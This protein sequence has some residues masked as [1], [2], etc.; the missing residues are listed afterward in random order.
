MKKVNITLAFDDEKLDA[1]EFSLKKESSSVQERMDETLLKLYEKTVAESLREY[2]ESRAVPVAKEK[3][4]RP[5]KS[6]TPKPQNTP[7]KPAPV[8]VPDAAPGSEVK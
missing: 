8:V 7:I 4:K 6:A 1:L 2:L 3:P 5:V